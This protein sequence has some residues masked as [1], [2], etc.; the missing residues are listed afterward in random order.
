M[1]IDSHPIS[2]TQEKSFFENGQ[3][4]LVDKPLH[5]TSFDV[6]NKIKHKI[7]HTFHLKKIKVGH[8]G[9]LDPL[10]TG[11]LIVCTGK[12]TK[13]IESFQMMEKVYTGTMI[14]GGTT[15]TYDSEFQPDKHFPTDHI[16]HEMLYATAMRLTGEIEQVPPIYSAVKV[17]GQTAYSL[18]RKGKEVELSA[19]KVFIYEFDITEINM[20]A[21]TF[22][23]R[24][25]KGTYI[26]TL[27]DD[28]GRMCGSGAYLGSLRRESIGSY[29]VSQARPV[30]DVVQWIESFQPSEHSVIDN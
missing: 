13:T 17:K 29:N 11:L 10:A 16:T 19:R 27:A 15:P 18:A 8:A 26:R 23:V 21:V 1:S 7:R 9:T 3:F 25:S 28:F 5:W 22:R 2:H 12:M 6:V 14:L 24:C 30:G 20:P 4:I